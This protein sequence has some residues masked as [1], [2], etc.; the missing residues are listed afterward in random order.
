MAEHAYKPSEAVP[1]SGVYRVEHN[2]HRET[3]DATLLQGEVFPACAI[4]E[5]GVRFTLKHRAHNIRH[6]KDF[7]AAK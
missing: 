1:V 4:C 6:D 2:G 7:P 5:S 3:H